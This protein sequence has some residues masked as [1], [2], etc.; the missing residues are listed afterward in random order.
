MKEERRKKTERVEISREEQTSSL[1]L[2]L[3]KTVCDWATNR[4]A[5]KKKKKKK[6]E[7]RRKEKGREEREKKERR[8]REEKS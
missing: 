1:S 5:I 4:K 6:K 3:F 2:A 8:K 7:V